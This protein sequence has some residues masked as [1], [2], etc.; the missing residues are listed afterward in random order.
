MHLT[1]ESRHAV[2]ACTALSLQSRSSSSASP[3][4]AE[5]LLWNCVVGSR[6]AWGLSWGKAL[7]FEAKA[8]HRIEEVRRETADAEQRSRQLQDELQ[9]MIKAHR[10]R[11]EDLD[12]KMDALNRQGFYFNPLEFIRDLACLTVSQDVGVNLD[13]KMDALSRQA[14]HKCSCKC[15]SNPL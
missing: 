5:G 14:H 7:L 1:D 12:R 10:D 11:E 15:S 3:Q 13:V 9:R 2:K 6:P 4:N 8:L